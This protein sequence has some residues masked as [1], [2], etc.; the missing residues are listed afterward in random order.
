[1]RYLR[2]AAATLTVHVVY[3]VAFATLGFFVALSVAAT[4]FT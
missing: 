3:G 2:R 1:M 4:T